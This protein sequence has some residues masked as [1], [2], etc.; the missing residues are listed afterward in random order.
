MIGV[1]SSRL[2]IIVAGAEPWRELHVLFEDRFWLFDGDGGLF[3]G[4]IRVTD[5]AE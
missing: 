2:Q 4:Y 5:H 3:R 1:A